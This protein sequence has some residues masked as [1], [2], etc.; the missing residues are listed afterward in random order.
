MSRLRPLDRAFLLIFLPLWMVVFVLHTINA[1]QGRLAEPGVYVTGPGDPDGFPVV[2]S[3]HIGAPAG[4]SGL[5]AGDELLRIGNSD[6]RG[7]G[8]V[9]FFAHAMQA[10]GSDQRAQVAYRR[11]GET[12]ELWLPYT[13]VPLPIRFFLV[14]VSFVATALLLILRAPRNRTASA[15]FRVMLIVAAG[16]L[17]PWGGPVAQTYLWMG[18][19]VCVTPFF[20]PLVIFAVRQFREGSEE[21]LFARVWPWIFLPVGPMY[22]SGIVG[23][24]L[25]DGSS[26]LADTLAMVMLFLLGVAMITELTI[27]YRRG[28]PI[29]RRQI[30]WIVYGMY[31]TMVPVLIAT[32]ISLSD[33]ELW[34]LSDAS[35]ILFVLIPVS[36]F[37]AITRYGVFDIDRIISATA[38]YSVLILIGV[39]IALTLAPALADAISQAIGMDP[40]PG[41]LLLSIGLVSVGV[42]AH[43][44]LDPRIDRWFFPERHAFE[45]QVLELLAELPQL[46]T[47]SELAMRASARIDEMLRPESCT[48]YLRTS[49]GYANIFARGRAVP[50]VFD[51][52]NPVISVL[53]ARGQPI[54]AERWARPRKD[55]ALSPFD[56]AALESLDAAVLVPVGRQNQL[57]GFVCLGP[58]RSGDLYTATDLALLGSIG[59]RVAAELD[60][61]DTAE[62]I[63]QGEEMQ[64]ALR[65]YVPGAVAA[66]LDTHGE[67]QSTKCE[68]SVLFVDI[69]GYT[70]YSQ[71]RGAEE[72]FS[73]VNQYTETVS[74]IVRQHAGSVVE[75]N[76]DGM[77]AV[78]GAPHEL[79]AKERAAVEAG[80]AILAAMGSLRVTGAGQP[81]Q[82]LSVGVGIA[83]GEAFVGNI[84]AVDRL[85]WSAI[86]NTTNRAARLESLTR[87]LA[88]TMVIDEATRAA[89]G[90]ACAGFQKRMRVPIRG[91]D[92]PTDLYV[93]P[94][95]AQ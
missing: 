87:E 32:A 50:P 12:H 91:Y 16:F 51:D 24:P 58:K 7:V 36:F 6:L 9:G 92:E 1:F 78:F 59:S 31:V 86:G 2:Q 89:A 43:R 20:A 67:I 70:A 72:I 21:G 3:I 39:P 56:R 29:G 4:S 74:K 37:I 94:L 5:V 84:H 35:E 69:R 76:G 88:A 41:R 18:L 46:K 93:L 65:R 80:R 38:S 17:R 48:C 52:R 34:W 45:E 63:R 55:T 14:S 13:P 19:L 27:S 23:I 60:R 95:H 90:Q 49:E 28:N 77:M 73:L 83:T 30:K 40:W 54:V 71:A 62:L 82:P 25:S 15:A 75:F 64:A 11:G 66:E 33:P 61:F 10:M 42:P 57:Y 22:F 68:V 85:I 53:Q 47:P 26:N 81:S 44:Y 79:V 8:P